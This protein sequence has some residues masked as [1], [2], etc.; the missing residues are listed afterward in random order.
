MMDS[1]SVSRN[2]PCSTIF[3]TISFF[4]CKVDLQYD[5]MLINL[6]EGGRPAIAVMPKMYVLSTP[7]VIS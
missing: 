3:Q 7:F 2:L 4:Y 5:D 1:H 6:E